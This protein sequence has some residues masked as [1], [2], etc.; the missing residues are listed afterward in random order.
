MEYNYSSLAKASTPLPFFISQSHMKM[1]NPGDE[2]IVSGI[3]GFNKVSFNQ[4]IS[5]CGVP[6]LFLKTF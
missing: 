5:I 6:S 2:F 1:V 4:R 3:I